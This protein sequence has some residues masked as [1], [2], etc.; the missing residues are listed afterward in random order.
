MTLERAFARV[1]MHAMN[2]AVARVVFRKAEQV[3][4]G[5]RIFGWPSVVCD[6]VLRIGARVEIVSTPA[7]V[8]IVVERGGSLEIGDDVVVESGVTIC[9]RGRVVIG[10]RASIGANATIDAT[11]L[12]IEDGARIADGASITDAMTS[13]RTARAA[14]TT[15]DERVRT[16][17]SSIVPG[18]STIDRDADL[19]TLPGWDSLAAL[20]ALVALEQ[21]LDARL[22][23]DLFSA[24]PTLASV[25]AATAEGPR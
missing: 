1:T 16:V 11:D 14:S 12:R 25:T 19:R 24:H 9:A 21:E 17:L 6:G 7:H 15:T 13:E 2:A 4:S 5:V 23:H 8:A 18:I 10:A 3:G 20:R 22:P